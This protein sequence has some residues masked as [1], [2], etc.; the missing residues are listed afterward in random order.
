MIWQEWIDGL[1]GG[2]ANLANSL[3]NRLR[4]L[5]PMLVNM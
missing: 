1:T 5:L 4:D 3:K 2:S